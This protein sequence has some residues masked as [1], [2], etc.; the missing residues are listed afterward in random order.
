MTRVITRSQHTLV[1]A[2]SLV[3]FA[4]STWAQESNAHPSQSVDVVSSGTND[5]NAANNPLESLLTVDLQDRF[6]PSPDGSPGKNGNAGQLRV[7]VPIETFGFHQFIRTIVPINTPAGAPGGPGLGNLT[8]YDILPFQASGLTFGA[9][10]LIAA[11]T[12]KAGAYGSRKWQA[13]AAAAVISLQTWG[14]LAVLTTYQHSFSGSSS[15]PSGALTTVQPFFFYHFADGV[16]FRSSGVMTFDTFH[17]TQY[18][19]IGFGL[20]RVWKRTNGDIVN[21]FIEPQYSVLQSGIGSPKWQIF[22]GATFKFPVGK[23]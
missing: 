22:T 7:A 1:M 3:L 12:G 17:H 14:L 23:R 11:P 8:V 20:G 16:Y 9:G 13:G 18:I 5:T 4:G 6:A 21:L 15:S 2:A 10:P 19:P